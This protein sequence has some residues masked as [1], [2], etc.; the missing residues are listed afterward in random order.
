MC[1]GSFSN[2]QILQ[3]CEFEFFI[4]FCIFLKRV[5]ECCLELRNYEVVRSLVKSLDLLHFSKSFHRTMC[6]LQR[7]YCLRR[8]GCKVLMLKFSFCT[9]W[10]QFPGNVRWAKNTISKYQ[11]I[12][13]SAWGTNFRKLCAV[14]YLFSNQDSRCDRK[15]S[16]NSRRPIPS[17]RSWCP[18]STSSWGMNV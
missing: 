18:H 14:G 6:H 11:K 2:V 1:S 8:A 7:S 17:L 12:F 10:T 16:K 4:L 5:P 3:N 15:L 9:F 13:C